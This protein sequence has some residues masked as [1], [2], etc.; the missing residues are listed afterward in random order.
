MSDKLDYSALPAPSR[1]GMLGA[2]SFEAPQSPVE[3][4]V[5]SIWK[6]LLEIE[7][8]GSHDNFFEL[9]GHSIL[10]ARFVDRARK[11]FG[12][13]VPIRSFFESPTVAGLA[14]EVEILKVSSAGPP[15]DGDAAEE[16]E[17][18]VL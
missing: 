11:T 7:E 10:V 18:F 15:V 16:R 5:A 6:E 4:E 9:G 13:E 3:E 17:E 2:E 14:R 1:E 12:V 8:V